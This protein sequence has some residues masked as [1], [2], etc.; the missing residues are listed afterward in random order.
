MARSVVAFVCQSCGASHPKW[1]GR[2]DDCGAWNSLVEEQ[3]A[4]PAGTSA[5]RAGKGRPIALETLASLAQ[6]PQR[7]LTG[8][9]EFDRVTGGGL[10]PGSAILLGG[11]PGV[12]KSTLMLQVLAAYAGAKKIAVYMSGEEALAQVRLRAARMGLAQAPVQL[13]A[14]TCV[15]DIL[16][17][18]SLGPTPDI[19]VIDSIQTVWTSALDAAPGTIAQ[20]RTATFDLV[21]YAKAN[22]VAVILIGHVTK[23][24]QIAG[25]R[26]VE[27]LVDAVL[28]FEGERGHHFRILRAVKNR[29]GATDEIGVFEMTGS[30][31]A[32]VTNPSALF[33]GDRSGLAPGT[34]VF[35]GME[36]T[37]PL[38][39][40]IQALTAPSGYGTPRR[41]VVGWDAGRLSMV[42]AVLDARAGLGISGQDIY[43]NVA[44]G[45]KIAEPAADLAAAA[46][47][48][49][50]FSGRPL[51][52]DCVVFGEIA[53]SGA[54]RPAA[55]SE[56]RLKEAAK[57]GFTRAFV[58]SNGKNQGGSLALEML[59]DV[60]DLARLVRDV[61]G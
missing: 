43:L 31:L 33:L 42:L 61:G 52:K 56:A 23:D 55:H 45:L 35:A 24:G 3:A 46:A 41:A 58:P 53:L 34:A 25:P 36:G 2:C 28:Y 19:L 17:T 37:R 27:H 12:G 8:V 51:P 32:Q 16:A 44:G 47:L 26:A 60:G 49:S 22:G 6:E 39:C 11:D 30:G 38:L 57:L 54:V 50:S 13:G 9:A 4:P 15:E 18:L 20:V 29:F 59:A 10:V 21:R 14:A 1:S 40:E 5:R 48:V 7:R